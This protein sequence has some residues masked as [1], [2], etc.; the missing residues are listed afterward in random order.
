MPNL[1][2]QVE[3][4]IAQISARIDA[5]KHRIK[6]DLSDSAAIEKDTLELRALNVRLEELKT[7][8]KKSADGKNRK[9]ENTP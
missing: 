9:D 6:G 5:E 3:L 4:E 1:A 2:A 7:T 8:L